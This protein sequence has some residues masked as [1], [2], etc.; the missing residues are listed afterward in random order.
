M[1]MF[2]SSG[3]DSSTCSLGGF[4]P[5]SRILGTG[6]RMSDEIAGV[7]VIARSG[8][9][10]GGGG[11]SDFRCRAASALGGGCSA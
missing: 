2:L 10:S 1:P 9:V 7:P 6:G 4:F 5:G 8:G 3:G 11:D